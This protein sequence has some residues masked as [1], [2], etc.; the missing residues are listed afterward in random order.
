MKTNIFRIQANNS[1]TCGY[2]CTGFIKTLID[3]T[4]LFLLYDFQID[5]NIIEN[6]F[7]NEWMNTI[8]SKQ[9][10]WSKKH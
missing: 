9:L 10:M 5:N 8:P 3:W 7:N 1:I 6:Y 2:C 4:N